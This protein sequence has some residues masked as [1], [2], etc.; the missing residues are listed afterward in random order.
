MAL[1][2]NDRERSDSLS[3]DAATRALS[4]TVVENDFVARVYEKLANVYDLVFGPTLHPGRLEAIQ[5][6]EHPAR[7]LGARG[8]RRHRHQP[9]RSIRRA[10]PSPASTSRRRCSTKRA[11]GSSRRSCATAASPRWMRRAMSFPGRILR[12]RLCAVS[13]QR[14]ARPG[15]GRAGNAPRLPPRRPHRHPQ[16]LQEPEPVARASSKPRSRRS[17][18]TSA[19][20][21]T[22]ISTAS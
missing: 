2:D 22:S 21:P 9:A 19:S 6:D 3:G 15:E 7:R 20:S 13:D 4:V 10:A 17:P 14:R 1:F 5:K 11:S 18:F 8:G 16:S 12:H